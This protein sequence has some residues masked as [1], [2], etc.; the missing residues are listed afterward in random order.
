MGVLFT[1]GASGQINFNDAEIH[2]FVDD[3]GGVEFG[4]TAAA[5]TFISFRSAVLPTDS[6]YTFRGN[7][8]VDATGLVFNDVISGTI[9]EIEAVDDGN[10]IFTLTGLAM[11]I[12][13]FKTFLAADNTQGFL[14]AVF[15]GNDTLLG[16]D[17][18]D[19]SDAMAGF[20]GNDS[21]VGAGG[22][23]NLR[24]D[25]GNDTLDGGGGS[26]TLTG[27]A[28]NDSLIGGD[29][30]DTYVIDSAKDV[31]SEA[32]AELEDRVVAPF[33]VDLTL[34]TF[35]GIEHVTLTGSGAF[36]L[37]GDEFGNMLIGNGGANVLDGGVFTD[38]L[39]SD[40]V[41]TLIGGAGNDIYIVR[42]TDDVIVELPGG[43]IDQVKAFATYTLS[44]QVEYLTLLGA[45]V[46][47]GF[48]NDLANRII[49]TDD[50]NFLEGVAG[51]DTLIGN[52]GADTLA[53]GTGTDIMTG[54]KG[55]DQYV[56]DSL[57]DKVFEAALPSIDRDQVVV[58][59]DN[60]VLAAN[61][62]DL[63]LAGATLA[64]N[65]T[66]NALGNKIEGNS[67]SF[68]T[69]L[70][71]AGNDTITG[72]VGGQDILLGGVDRKSVV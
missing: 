39:G 37:T 68:N 49:G 4:P 43:G 36:K 5:A 54:G 24:G 51:N 2:D 46:I 3:T 66:G 47:H 22:S 71:L 52:G 58:E 50:A 65:G 69:L 27:G 34:A 18:Q 25:A 32:G 60:Y 10:T 41:D 59:I 57:A 61:V 56:V 40:P 31:I 14:A 53:G 33:A 13:A 35:D 28:G 62:E 38:V 64:Q 11:S 45:G 19:L 8:V 1:A 6:R 9:N 30:N 12:P 15:A 70:G 17:K 55:A 7:F 63:T 29:G 21:I 23:D 42:E 16:S 67:Y 20:A 26:D 44:A 72:G 48:G